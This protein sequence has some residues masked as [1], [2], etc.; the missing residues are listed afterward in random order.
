VQNQTTR[1]HQTPY[2]SFGDETYGQR[3]P[4]H[5]VYMFCIFCK[6]YIWHI[7]LSFFMLVLLVL[8][9]WRKTQLGILRTWCFFIMCTLKR[10]N[11]KKTVQ[12]HCTY[13]LINKWPCLQYLGNKSKL[14]HRQL[15]ISQY[16][17][18][19]KLFWPVKPV[20]KTTY[21][22]WASLSCLRYHLCNFVLG[23]GLHK[24]PK[25]NQDCFS[26]FW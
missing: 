17:T 18:A 14:L 23:D 16:K 13:F 1:F 24:L 15:F 21:C 19:M 11:I 3:P 4:P 7:H 26:S 10:P 5:N 12:Q 25:Y 8:S 22:V 9:H 6:E 2:G 20:S